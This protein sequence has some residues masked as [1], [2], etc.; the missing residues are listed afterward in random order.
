MI[1][2]TRLSDPVPVPV[3]VR[4]RPF[5]DL[6]PSQGELSTTGYADDVGEVFAWEERFEGGGVGDL[7]RFGGFGI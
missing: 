3:V 7:G 4:N 5:S 2:Q 6:L 1:L